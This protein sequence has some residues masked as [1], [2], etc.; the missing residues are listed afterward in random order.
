M[1]TRIATGLTTALILALALTPS[2]TAD[3]VYHSQHIALEPV[4]TAPLRSGF[5][6][7]VH[8][9]GPTIYAHEI[10]VLNGAVPNADLEVH[11]VA[12]LFD[13]TCSGLPTDFGAVPL[14]TNGVGNGSADRFFAPADVPPAIRHAT[15]G[16]RWEVTGTDGVLYETGCN[17]VTLD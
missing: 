9:N 1:H 8:P 7:N 3:Q 13:P 6:E 15:H 17:A 16:I 4:S 10:Y 5:V 11:L 12:Y 2:A 14:D